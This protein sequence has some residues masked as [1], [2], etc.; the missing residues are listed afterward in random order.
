MQVGDNVLVINGMHQNETGTVLAIDEW[1]G[2]LKVEIH[3][4][5]G[6]YNIRPEDVVQIGE[7]E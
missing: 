1:T 4:F 5:D 6:Y 2:C 3:A 7:E